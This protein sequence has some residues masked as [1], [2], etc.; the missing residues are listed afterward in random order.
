MAEG[1][2]SRSLVQLQCVFR[3]LEAVDT[4]PV[5]QRWHSPQQ[6]PYG[7]WLSKVTSMGLLGKVCRNDYHVTAII[8][9]G[10]GHGD[11]SPT[12]GVGQI[13]RN[14]VIACSSCRVEVKVTARQLSQMRKKKPLASHPRHISKQEGPVVRCPRLTLC[15]RPAICQVADP[16]FKCSRRLF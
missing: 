10:T 1:A 6:L 3:D 14:M 4:L 15:N 12:I 8:K 9:K 7:Y 11:G 2:P 16:P 5:H 13:R